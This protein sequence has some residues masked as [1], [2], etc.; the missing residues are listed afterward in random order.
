[1]KNGIISKTDMENALAFQNI[2]KEAQEELDS[3]TPA[4][5]D[6]EISLRS[7]ARFP[8]LKEEAMSRCE[9]C[10]EETP[11]IMTCRRCSTKKNTNHEVEQN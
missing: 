1:M 8:E 5:L 7:A 6:H 10:A 9:E 2:R 3:R 4:T 11:G